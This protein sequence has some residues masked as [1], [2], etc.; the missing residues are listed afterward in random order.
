MSYKY[1]LLEWEV[2]TACNAAC[3]QCPRN[4]YGG[5]TWHTLP[6]IQNSLVW[7]K[8]HLPTDFVQRLRRVDF[9]GTYGDPIVNTELVSIVSWL[10]EVNP[11]LSI[12]IKTNGG[13]KDKFWWTQLAKTLGP[14]GTVFFG[15]DGLHDTNHLYRKKTNFNKIIENA[16]AFIK[17]GGVANWNYIV[18]KHNEHQID[19]ARRLSSELGFANFNLKLTGRF[20]NKN[21]KMVDSIIVHNDK[22]QTDYKIELPTHADYVNSAYTQINTFAAESIN[23]NCKFMNLNRI[24]LSAEGFVFPCG[25]L[26]DRMYGYEAEQHP[27]HQKLKDLFELAGGQQMANIN[28]TSIDKIVNGVWFDTLQESWSNQKTTLDRCKIMCGNSADLIANQNKLVQKF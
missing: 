4:Y 18:F 24:Y 20:F 10:L 14:N 5:K 6:I 17:A 22:N 26:H 3:P 11:E 19:E 21:H 1:D 25:W 16:T 9:C 13:L 28:Y 15:I 27:D 8:Q 23:I 12:S 7:A 2:T